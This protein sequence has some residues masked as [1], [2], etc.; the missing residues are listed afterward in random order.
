LGKH[1]FVS[2]T[3]DFERWI[4][5]ALEVERLFVREHCE[6]TWRDG[7]FTGDPEEYSK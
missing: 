3:K 1:K 5:G 2:F 7:Y 6:G 4:K